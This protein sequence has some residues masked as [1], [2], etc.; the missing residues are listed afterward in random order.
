[1]AEASTEHPRARR[2]AGVIVTVL[3]AL[4]GGIGLLLFFVARDDAPVNSNGDEAGEVRGPGQAFPDQGARHVPPGQRG[5]ARYNSDP[6][7]SGP[8]VAQAVRGDAIALTDD[9]VLH[10]LELGNVVLAYGSAAPPPALRRLALETSGPF[11]PALVQAGQAVLLDRRPGTAG[12]IALAW[13]HLL[14]T[15]SPADPKLRRFVEFWLGRG[16]RQ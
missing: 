9:Q 16:A 8:H 4:A 10:A 12:A 11:D 14:R 3:V 5:E 7:T 13:R 1:V 15:S 6:P 2:A